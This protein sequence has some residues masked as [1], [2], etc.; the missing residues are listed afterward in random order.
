M[1][2]FNEIW[3]LEGEFSGASRKCIK[4]YAIFSE[5][6]WFQKKRLRGLLELIQI[7]K[8][9]SL[10]KF[11]I[12]T[13]YQNYTLALIKDERASHAHA[14]ERHFLS[15]QFLEYNFF[16]LYVPSIRNLPTLC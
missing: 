13:I 14:H 16:F 9:N 1:L 12:F 8:Q 3:P 10:E 11:L 6:W 7:Y 15:L 5:N 4:F 2:K